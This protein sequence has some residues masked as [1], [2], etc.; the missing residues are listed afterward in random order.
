MYASICISQ[1]SISSWNTNTS[2]LK[3]RPGCCLLSFPFRPVLNT[4]TSML[5][6]SPRG[7]ATFVPSLRGC[8]SL[9]TG[10]QPPGCQRLD[11]QQVAR[12]W[13]QSSWG[14]PAGCQALIAIWRAEDWHLSWFSF[15]V[16]FFFLDDSK[17]KV[18]RGCNAAGGLNVPTKTWQT[19]GGVVWGRLFCLRTESWC[20]MT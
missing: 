2:L 5:M 15:V 7:P 17:V 10:W 19:G 13:S 1:S 14:M 12:Y 11:N 8:L 9:G 3:N 18:W 6:G 20:L 16:P 4:Q